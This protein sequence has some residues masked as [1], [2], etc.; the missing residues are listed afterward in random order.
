MRGTTAGEGRAPAAASD[1]DERRTAALRAN[2]K[3]RKLQARGR[4]EAGASPAERGDETSPTV[5]GPARTT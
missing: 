3:R 1:R 2:L 5:I 4:A